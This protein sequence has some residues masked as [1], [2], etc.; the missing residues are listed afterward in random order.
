MT[1][2]WLSTLLIVTK[3]LDKSVLGKGKH[4]LMHTRKTVSHKED[5]GFGKIS[6]FKSYAVNRA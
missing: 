2:E 3:E 6:Q 4:V 1:L 5:N